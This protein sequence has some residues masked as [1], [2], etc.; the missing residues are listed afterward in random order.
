MAN[1]STHLHPETGTFFQA[2][3]SA[4]VQYSLPPYF[5]PQ[6][7]VAMASQALGSS[8]VQAQGTNVA[9]NYP[10]YNYLQPQAIN[11]PGIA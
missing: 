11:S 9:P 1:R 5:F 6:A 10:T 3:S 4:H 7:Q 2:E 8:T